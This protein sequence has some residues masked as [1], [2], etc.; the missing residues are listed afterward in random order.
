MGVGLTEITEDIM[1]RVIKSTEEIVDEIDDC[2][3]R[4][5]LLQTLL[6]NDD[7]N[8]FKQMI[9]TKLKNRIEEFC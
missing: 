6:S 8:E 7:Y 4:T 3:K 5:L 2:L 1:D 9:I